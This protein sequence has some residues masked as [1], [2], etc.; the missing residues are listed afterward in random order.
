MMNAD[1]GQLLSGRCS[2]GAWRPRTIGEPSR[3]AHRRASRSWSDLRTPP[4]RAARSS[5]ASRRRLPAHLQ[6]AR[7]PRAD[8]ACARRRA[9]HRTRPRA[10]DRRRL[11]RRHRASSRTGSR[12]S[13]PGSTSSIAPTKEGLGPGVRRRLPARARRRRRARARDGL[14]LL[15]RSRRRPAADRAPARTA[16]ISPSARATSPAA[17][18]S[19]GASGGASSRVAGRS[20]RGSSWASAIRD[21]T[22]GFKCFR[23]ATLEAIDL[24]AI[25]RSRLRVPD[26]GHLPRAARG[27]CGS[28]RCRSRSPTG[29]WESRR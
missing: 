17:A 28:S 25:A 21:L 11:A 7:E 4:T 27:A 9:R 14:R 26:R 13:S 20:T 5:D 1:I 22:G 8:G 18:R 2:L 3:S 16:P 12:P 24:D 10:R 6:R 29:A 23:R 19:T 15:P